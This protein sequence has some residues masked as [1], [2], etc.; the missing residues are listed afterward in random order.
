MGSPWVVGV[1]VK[2]YQLFE[3]RVPGLGNRRAGC[4]RFR[5]R[6]GRRALFR[7]L[8]DARPARTGRAPWRPGPSKQLFDKGGLAGV[9][10]ERGE[11]ADKGQHGCDGRC[12]RGNL[13]VLCVRAPVGAG[14]RSPHRRWR[15]RRGAALPF[16]MCW[17]RSAG[18][19]QG[20]LSASRE[21]RRWY[22]AI[23]GFSAGEGRFRQKLPSASTHRMRS[24]PWGCQRTFRFPVGSKC[25]RGLPAS[26]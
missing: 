24:R 15:P 14:R 13:A 3:G 6:G 4:G 21:G 9:M 5:K 23:G 8:A 19:R 16:A 12:G 18:R 25:S 1:R 26:R 10:G 20:G 17:S 11:G 2:R 7:W 22:P